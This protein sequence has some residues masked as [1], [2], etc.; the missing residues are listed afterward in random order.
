MLI[1]N[2][3]ALIIDT[4]FIVN[5]LRYNWFRDYAEENFNLSD[6]PK[7][8][9]ISCVVVG[10]LK[11]LEESLGWETKM[12]AGL[13]RFL[14]Q[15]IVQAINITD[16]YEAYKEIDCFSK[17]P[18]RGFSARKM[19]KNDVWIAATARTTGR[20]LLTCDKDFCHI[21]PNYINRFYVGYAQKGQVIMHTPQSPV[22]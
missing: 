4:C 13:K 18:G 3:D 16:I 15:F 22:P 12:R 19:G 9:M 11:V 1:G 6:H 10:E 17:K 21:S 7:A 5:Y 14:D 8:H 20:I 2:N